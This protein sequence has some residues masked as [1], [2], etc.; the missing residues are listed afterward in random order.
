MKVEFIF[1]PKTPKGC[2]LNV[3]EIQDYVNQKLAEFP[4][5]GNCESVT[6]MS[7]WLVILVDFPELKAHKRIYH[8]PTELWWE[9]LAGYVALQFD[10]RFL[11]WEVHG[12]TRSLLYHEEWEKEKYE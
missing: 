6:H 8:E 7:N 11:H 4:F 9:V 1:R 5:K 10:V 2:S 3:A 12:E